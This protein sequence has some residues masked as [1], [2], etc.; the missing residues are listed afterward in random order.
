MSV[1]DCKKG[2]V[3]NL[4]GKFYLVSEVKYSLSDDSVRLVLGKADKVSTVHRDEVDTPWLT[5]LAQIYTEGLRVGWSGTWEIIEIHTEV[6][7]P[8]LF[9]C[10]T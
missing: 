8:C 10:H 3:F 7:N 2:V 9:F 6:P 4:R 5:N 1:P